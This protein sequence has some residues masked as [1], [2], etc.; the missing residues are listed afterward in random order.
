MTFMREACLFAVGCIVF[1]A[2]TIL[3]DKWMTPNQSAGICTGIAAAIIIGTF[4]LAVPKV[5]P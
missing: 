4:A 5:R 2:A 3:A 1:S